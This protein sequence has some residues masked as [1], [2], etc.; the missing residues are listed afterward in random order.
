M[1]YDDESHRYIISM[2][3]PP[4]LDDYTMQVLDRIC[5]ALKSE[6]ESRA[7]KGERCLSGY[8]KGSSFDGETY[9]VYG[10]VD[11]LPSVDD[12]IPMY[13]NRGNRARIWRACAPQYSLL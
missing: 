13:D 7:K 6:C 9:H 4:D 3:K 11:Y 8:P 12:K 1:R 10:F 5:Y 2:D